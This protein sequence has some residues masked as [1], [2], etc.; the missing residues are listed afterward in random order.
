LYKFASS[1]GKTD[2]SSALFRIKE[3]YKDVDFKSDHDIDQKSTLKLKPSYSYLEELVKYTYNNLLEIDKEISRF[4]TKSW[5]ITNLPML[6][7]SVLRVGICELAY[8]PETPKKVIINEY[9][10]IAN[11]MLDENEIGFVNSILHN[12]AQS[13][14]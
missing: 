9:T 13:R 14:P 11:D 1:Q 10:D 7:L 12:Y 4:L 5:T 6:L 8:F 2:I 3:F